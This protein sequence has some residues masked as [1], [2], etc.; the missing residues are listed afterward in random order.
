MLCVFP[1]FSRTLTYTYTF[2]H[3]FTIIERA[4]KKGKKKPKKE[5]W[6]GGKSIG[7]AMLAGCDRKRGW[8]TG[9]GGMGLGTAIT[10]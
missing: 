2:I 6:T 3:S 7:A 8:G 9:E 4:K 1:S 10:V 5:N